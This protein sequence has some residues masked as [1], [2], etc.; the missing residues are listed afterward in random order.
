[1]R[2]VFLSKSGQI[3]VEDAPAPEVGAGEVLVE[4]AYSLISTGT[5]TASVASAKA[6]LGERIA[7]AVRLAKLGAQRLQERGLEETLRKARVREGISAPMGY[8]VAGV[9]RAVGSEVADLAAGQRVAAAGSAYAHHAEVVAVPRNLVVPVPEPVGLREASFATV[10]AI[11]LQGVRRAMPQ[12]GE[13]A[14]VIGLGLVGQLTVQILGAAG[15]RV[16]GVDPRA[17]RVELARRGPGGLVAGC[18]PDSSDVERAVAEATGG[19]GADVVLLCAGTASSEPANTALRVVR[20]RGRVVVVGAVGMELSREPFYRKEV[21]F[22]ISCSYGPG[23]YD[24]TYEEGGLD[25]PVAFVRWTENRNL[26]GF[27]DLVARGRID[28]ASL[29]A[30]E[31]EIEDAPEAFR[32]E[33][34]TNY[35][36][37]R[38]PP[39]LD[40]QRPNETSWTYFRKV[41]PVGP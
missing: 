40:D 5:E 6:D 36:L 39:P 29:L 12:V 28:P 34:E 22:T 11:A 23:R 32:K 30:S 10:G 31:H 24:P 15:C 1:M 3:L 9:V 38:S 20:Q 26:A 35:P 25:Y 16:V 19:I 7:R 14:V 21:E 27:L 4:V 13:T 33:I 41:T 8:S 17:D 37:Y 2:Q 18:G